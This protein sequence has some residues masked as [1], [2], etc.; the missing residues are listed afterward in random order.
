M[1]LSG[2]ARRSGFHPHYFRGPHFNA[3]CV[4]GRSH[5]L[6][7]RQTA[8]LY[9]QL[10]Y[11]ASMA[12]NYAMIPIPQAQRTVLDHTW[13]LPPETVPLMHA[14][15]RTLAAPVVARDALPPFPASIKARLGCMGCP[16]TRCKRY[17]RCMA[18]TPQVG[19]Q[20]PQTQ[21]C[22]SFIIPSLLLLLT[23]SL[24][25]TLPAPAQHTPPHQ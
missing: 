6:C 5:P 2:V 18:A 8:Q 24:L 4:D 7:S 20:D 9:Q 15:G 10:S 12:S 17:K 1:L 23:A 22:D 21:W 3:L 11:S 16:L 14:L 25:C 19:D 13:V